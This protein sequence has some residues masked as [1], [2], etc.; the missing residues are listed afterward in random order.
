MDSQRGVD[1]Q[2][3][4]QGL[5]TESRHHLM[6]TRCLVLLAALVQVVPDRLA[7][8]QSNDAVSVADASLDESFR[9]STHLVESWITLPTGAAQL[10][11]GR[12]SDA[13]P[14]QD[15]GATMQSVGAS[16]LGVSRCERQGIIH[17]GSCPRLTLLD[18][19]VRLQI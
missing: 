18:W 6:F 11:A 13:A 2:S 17:G 1:F 5:A 9:C 14:I 12:P 8:W 3:T 16:H 4:F 7:S 15:A 10:A 19:N